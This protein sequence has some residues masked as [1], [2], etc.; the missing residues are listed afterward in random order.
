MV[1][2]N[3]FPV[4]L[5]TSRGVYLQ[6]HECPFTRANKMRNNLSSPLSFVHTVLLFT[7][8]L[9]HSHTGE[10]KREWRMMRVDCVRWITC[11]EGWM[12]IE[13]EKE[14]TGEPSVWSVIIWMLLYLSVCLSLPLLLM[15][16]LTFNLLPLNPPSLVS[17]SVS[18]FHNLPLTLKLLFFLRHDTPPLSFTWITTHLYVCYCMFHLLPLSPSLSPSP[19][20]AEYINMFSLSLNAVQTSPSEKKVE[21]KYYWITVKLNAFISQNKRKHLLTHTTH[22][23]IKLILIN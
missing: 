22:T 4:S 5:C 11:N 6:I 8:S 12:S 20:S 17:T 13:R 3:S 15:Q 16:W 23:G 9:L 18:G 2:S 10:R 14:I 7:F 21:N 19:H 1:H